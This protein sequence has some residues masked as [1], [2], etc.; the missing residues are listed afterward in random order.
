MIMCVYAF[1]K[2]QTGAYKKNYKVLTVAFYNVENLFDTINNPM[3]F[4]DDRTPKGKEHWTS[5]KY[6]IKIKNT[7]K[8]ISEIGYDIAQNSPAIIGLCEVENRQVVKDVINDSALI[9]KK[10]GIAHFDSPDR[11]GIDVALIYQKKLF[12]PTSVKKHALVLNDE[13]NNNKRIY[14]RDQLVVSGELDTE[15]IH[16][17]VNHWPSRR[18]GTSRSSWR[19]VA[20]ARLNV[21]IIDSI[22]AIYPYAK[23]IVMGDFNDD[24]TNKSIKKVLRSEPKKEKVLKNELFNPMAS[25][26]KKGIGTLA[27]QD[28]WNIFDQIM[29]NKGFINKDFNTYQYYKAHVFNKH[30]LLNSKGKYKG[31]PFRSYANG[32]FTGGYSDHFPVYVLLIKLKKNA[33]PK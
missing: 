29:I 32:M 17:I 22:N 23:I 8:V 18:G 30:Y 13:K 5:K 16:I 7:A 21:K 10:Y 14:T 31:Y 6:A 11:R 4:D 33:T 27:Y 26:H 2:A 1:A 12:K 20:A 25:L 3:T 28:Q 15:L 9:A 24:P 19:R